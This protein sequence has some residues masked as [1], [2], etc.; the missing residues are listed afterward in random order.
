MALR[1]RVEKTNGL[2]IPVLA[3]LGACL[4]WLIVSHSFAAYFA[5]SAPEL[6]LALNGSQPTALMKLA[7][8]RLASLQPDSGAE[9]GAANGGGNASRL[10]GFAANGPLAE[11]GEERGTQAEGPLAA[12]DAAARAE[13]RL[14]AEQA[15]TADP[16]DAGALFLLGRIAE[17]EGSAAA[18]DL[19]QAA[20]RRSLRQT[21]A[22]YY[23]MQRSFEAQDYA[24]T[25]DRA[26]AILRTAP[27]MTRYIVPVLGR[28]AEDEDAR[29]RLTDRLAA[30]PPWRVAFL[31][32]LP[33]AITDARTPLNI[34][35]ALRDSP[36]PPTTADLRGYLD[37]LIRKGFHELA[38]YAWLQFLPPEDLSRAGLIYNGSFER[39]PSGLPFDW[40]IRTG[41]GVMVQMSP[42]ADLETGRALH[43]EFGHGRV[44]FGSVAQL[45]LLAPG[46]YRFEGRLRGE[47]AG[48]RGLVWQ[49]SCAGQRQKVLGRSEMMTGLAPTWR[50]FNFTF[51][52][53]ADQQCRAQD[54]RLTLDAR[55]ASERFVSGAV[56]YA[57]LRI[58]RVNPP[59]TE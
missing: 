6:A 55:S 58:V 33:Q 18:T 52:V 34:L 14:L 8:S 23:M 2:R 29:T 9:A 11:S 54:L 37:F 28:I 50:A 59:G 3:G 16:L 4:V 31:S 32:G 53:P 49:I 46:A 30:K 19:M 39:P 15:L 51:E 1:D 13:I 47:L 22:V 43:V 44:D 20:A 10:S 48:R 24:E 5:R 38:Y 35:L 41:P 57:D 12:A 21:G 36:A 56:W 45:T 27:R 7:R 42:A 25:L 26:D 17:A 40:V